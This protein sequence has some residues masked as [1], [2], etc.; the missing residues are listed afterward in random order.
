MMTTQKPTVTETLRDAAANSTIIH[1]VI[2][3]AGRTKD[4]DPRRLYRISFAGAGGL[5]IRHVLEGY[6]G[7]SVVR[8]AVGDHVRKLKFE[9]NSI[10][11]TF[12]AYAELLSDASMLTHRLID[13]AMR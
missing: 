6:H 3:D 11:I 2:L 9:R 12:K 5:A 10:G 4:G 7:D 8:L 13:E 1:A